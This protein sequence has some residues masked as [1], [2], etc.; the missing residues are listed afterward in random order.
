MTV[1]I[2]FALRKIRVERRKTQKQLARLTGL[3]QS[4]IS[5]LE[6]GTKR[7]TLDTIEIISTALKVH[8]YEL[9]ECEEK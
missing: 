6:L 8:P 1:R 2:Q 7:P 4:Y 9:L 5:E 3:S